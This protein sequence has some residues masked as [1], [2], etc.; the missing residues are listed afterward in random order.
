M[1]FEPFKRAYLGTRQFMID[2][3]FLCLGSEI[4]Q[5]IREDN[6]TFTKIVAQ[7]AAPYWQGSLRHPFIVQ[8]QAGTL[9]LDRFR[10]YLIQDHYYLQHFSRLHQLVANRCQDTAL[11]QIMRQGAID[12]ASG[13][14][15]LRQQQFQALN[16][17]EQEV[18]QTPI[19]PT[20]DHYIAHLYRQLHADNAAVAAAAL[21]PCAWLY[22]DI[23]VALQQQAP[24]PNRYYQEWIDLYAGEALQDEIRATG[25]VLDRLYAVSCKDDREQM[26]AAFVRSSQLEYHF[27][28]MAYRKE[29]WLTG[30]EY[31]AQ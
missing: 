16:I 31:D 24:S 20:T 25:E 23:G 3:S 12:L 10:Y 6:M 9:P 8:L 29:T 13:E 18:K 17:T 4:F 19:A 27:W 22:G 2:G 14:Q 21:Y 1:S 26:V 11:R 7:K 28:E 30:D 15:Q 5:L